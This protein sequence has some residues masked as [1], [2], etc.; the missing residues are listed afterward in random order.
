MKSAKRISIPIIVLVMVMVL[1]ANMFIIPGRVIAV[2]TEGKDA[3]GFNVNWSIVDNLTV[4]KGKTVTVTLST[5]QAVTGTV[6]DV[7]GN[8]LHLTKISQKEFYDSLILIDHI[9]AVEA[10][11]R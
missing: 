1:G 5:G 2:E 3:A 4:F 7:Q 6:S 8:L 9:S 11:V 10:K